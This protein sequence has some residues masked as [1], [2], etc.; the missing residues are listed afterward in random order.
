ML[1]NKKRIPW[2]KGRKG[3]QIAWNKGLKFPELS[4][5][6]NAAWKPKIKKICLQCKKE[7]EVYSS[8][9]HLK[10]CSLICSNKFRK[11][12]PLSIEWCKAISKSLKGKLNAGGFKKGQNSGKKNVNWKGGIP[13]CIDCGKKLSHRGHI[14]CFK[15]KA[16]GQK[17]E[18]HWKWK[19][20][21]SKDKTKWGRERRKFRYATD[22]N[23]RLML[24]FHNYKR[25]AKGHITLKTVQLVYEDNIKK[26]GTLTCYLCGKPVELRQDC[27]EHKTPL[28]RGGTNDY[29]NLAIAHRS[30]NNKK[31]NK[32]E[33]EFR[34]LEVQNVS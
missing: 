9:R 26:Y 28:S 23:Y 21:I 19:G 20:G 13:N 32:T 5:E 8:A 18:K 7:F 31:S 16:N 24:L 14:R 1:D 27:L 2:N 3:L 29:D 11:G 15:C 33:E 30:C 25:M 4:G 22:N 34:N 10:C 6:N 17:G 12:K